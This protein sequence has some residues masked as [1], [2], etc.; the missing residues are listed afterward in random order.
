MLDYDFRRVPRVRPLWAVCRIVG[1]RP[2]TIRTDR[3]RR[4][5]HVL[6]V[7]A[8]RLCP[9]EIVALQAIMGSDDRREALNLMRVI[10]IRKR[11]PAPF[12]RD[13]WNILFERKL[14]K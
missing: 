5:W 2:L 9:A 12:W 4:G 14:Q 8:E 10:A 7:L 1:V 11:P 13:R 3:T 6:I